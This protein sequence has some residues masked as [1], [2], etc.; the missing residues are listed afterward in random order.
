MATVYLIERGCPICSHDLKG[1]DE[2]RYFCRNCNILFDHKDIHVPPKEYHEPD[3]VKIKPITR[4]A[5]QPNMIGATPNAAF[6]LP[7]RDKEETMPL[8]PKKKEFSEDF[9]EQKALREV[10]EVV[11]EEKKLKKESELE[12]DAVEAETEPFEDE[13]AAPTGFELEGEEKIVASKEST[14]LHAGNCRFISKIHHNNR[15]YFASAAEGQVKGY[16]LCVCLRRIRAL[17]RP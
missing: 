15:Q 11:E 14:K 9:D 7:S 8:F 10:P 17:K 4:S 13:L 6:L 2:L 5:T 3:K 1:N 16:E 12:A